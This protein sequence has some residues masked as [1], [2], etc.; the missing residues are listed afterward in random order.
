[1]NTSTRSE[2][3][4]GTAAVRVLDEASRWVNRLLAGVAAIALLAMMFITV[5]DILLRLVGLQIAGTYELVGWL[6]AASMGLALGYVQVHHGHVSMSIV[7]DHLRGRP[8]ALVRLITAVLS[9]ALIAAVTYYVGSYGLMQKAT[10]SL[11]ETLRFIV[12]PWVLILTLGL[13]SLTL[14]LLVDALKSL[15]MLFHPLAFG[16]DVSAT[17]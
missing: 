13:A 14:A 10:G 5:F 3:S 2:A 17:L 7:S 11:S 15:V 4:A 12:Y 1:M 6:A 16:E 8:A 9:L